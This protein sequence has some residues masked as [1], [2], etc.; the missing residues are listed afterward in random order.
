MEVVVMRPLGAGGA[1]AGLG[2]AQAGFSLRA[3]DRRS[4]SDEDV[5]KRRKR[6]EQRATIRSERETSE[7]LRGRS[8]NMVMDRQGQ[9][10]QLT[11]QEG[12]ERTKTKDVRCTQH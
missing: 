5:T 8:H 2:W 9:H 11:K 6:K 1:W 7:R 10:T 4:V 3:N 12:K